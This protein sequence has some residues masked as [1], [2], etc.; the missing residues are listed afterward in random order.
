MCDAAHFIAKLAWDP[1]VLPMYMR[2][3]AMEGHFD[4]GF[5]MSPR[6]KPAST[7]E[8][9]PDPRCN[10]NLRLPHAAMCGFATHAVQ[11]EFATNALEDRADTAAQDALIDT[12]RSYEWTAR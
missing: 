8:L 3:G 12:V 4:M 9:W 5:V 6:S 11:W 10:V 7:V 2:H 1:M